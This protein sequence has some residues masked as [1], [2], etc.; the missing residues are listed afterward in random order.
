MF[1]IEVIDPDE[2]DDDNEGEIEYMSIESMQID[3]AGIENHIRDQGSA[4]GKNFDALT[5][6]GHQGN[7][8]VRHHAR[9][10]PDG[11]QSQA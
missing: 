2:S 5:E 8:I 4:A 3:V 10:E 11:R 6:H 1:C 7:R 9:H